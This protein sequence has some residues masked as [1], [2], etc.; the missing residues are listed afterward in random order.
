VCAKRSFW[1][2]QALLVGL[3]LGDVED[4]ALQCHDVAVLDDG[5]AAFEH[6]FRLA[7]SRLDAVVRRE[8]APFLDPTLYGALEVV[9]VLGEDEV[10][11]EE[12]RGFERR[13]GVAGER[14]DLPP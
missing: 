14:F 1:R 13:G 8:L 3:P 5:H 10:P 4:D 11:I 9:L 6:V 7:G 2:T 12:V